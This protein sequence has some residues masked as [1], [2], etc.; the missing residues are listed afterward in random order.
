MNTL[1]EDVSFDDP[2]DP[3][4][5]GFMT[6]QAPRAYRI[7]DGFKKR[8]K[9]VEEKTDTVPRRLTFQFGLEGGV[10]LIVNFARRPN[11]QGR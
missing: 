5:I 11:F 4:S 6:P 9:K 10:F 2:A 7:G 1:F 8:G 3:V